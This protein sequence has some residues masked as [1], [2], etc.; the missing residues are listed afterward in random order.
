MPTFRGTALTHEAAEDLFIG[1]L[2]GG[3]FSPTE[4]LPYSWLVA[5][6]KNPAYD[7]FPAQHQLFYRGKGKGVMWYEPVFKVVTLDGEAVWRRRRYRVRRGDAPGSFH[8]SVLDNGVTSNEFWRILDCA[9]DLEWCLFYYSGAAAT[10]GM[11]YSGA[12]LATHTGAMPS[13]AEALTRLEAAL[14]GA[15]IKTWELSM[16]DNS[17]GALAGA[18]LALATS[19]A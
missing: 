9:D 10:A 6:G 15:G 17:P 12:V 16:V 8:F 3:Q 2:P 5:A 14:D 11:S 4:P 1:W 7:F 19:G 13:G 18:P